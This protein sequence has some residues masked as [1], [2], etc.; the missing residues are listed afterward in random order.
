MKGNP[1]N[2]VGFGGF[3]FLLEIGLWVLFGRFQHAA[4]DRR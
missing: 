1:P 4:R 3:V 2:L